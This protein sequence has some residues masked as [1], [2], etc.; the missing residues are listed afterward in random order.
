MI[1]QAQKIENKQEIEQISGKESLKGK[2]EKFAQ[3]VATNTKNNTEAARGAGYKDNK[4]LR[5]YAFDLATNPNILARIAY[6]RAETAKKW[7]ITKDSQVKEYI[8]IR[9]R[10]VKA[11]DLRAEISANNSIDKLCGL[12]VDKIQT[13]QTDAQKQRSKA[14]K[15]LDAEWAEFLLDREAKRLK[16]ASEAVNEVILDDV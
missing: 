14:E 12:I 8:G 10:A 6:L 16:Q 9:D 1:V 13:E 3:L 5:R 11:G 7:D 2:R 15:R 4:G